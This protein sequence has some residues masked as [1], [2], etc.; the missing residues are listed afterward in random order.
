[1]KMPVI[2]GL[3]NLPLSGRADVEV[4]LEDITQADSR[5]IVLTKTLLRGVEGSASFELE[6][7]DSALEPSRDYALTAFATRPHDQARRAGTV[8]VHPWT[9]D[10]TRV[11][12]LQLRAFPDGR[13]EMP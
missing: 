11:Q 7:P 5:S 8:A 10:D 4:A 2:R 1:M 6:V 3:F 12:L 9:P 13:G